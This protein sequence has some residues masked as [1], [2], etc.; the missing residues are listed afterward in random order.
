MLIQLTLG[1]MNLAVMAAVAVVIAL[2]KLFSRG[3]WVA[4][5][6]GVAA[7]IGG[8]LVILRSV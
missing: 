4:R 7:I 1:V 6:T 5:I 8:I 3:E 2:E